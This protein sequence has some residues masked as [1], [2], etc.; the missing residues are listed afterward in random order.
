MGP[1]AADL[2]V[3]GPLENPYFADNTGTAELGRKSTRG[4]AFFLVARVLTGVGQVISVLFLSRLLSPEDYGVVAMVG[5]IT[6]FA[7]ILVDLGTRDAVVQQKSV[8]ENE[9]S[10]LF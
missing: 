9:V 2:R 3:H 5:A 10:A 8:S 6:G 4:G 1:I 7:P